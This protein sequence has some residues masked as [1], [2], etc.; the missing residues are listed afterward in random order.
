MAA[1]ARSAVCVVVVGLTA[2][3]TPAVA[4]AAPETTITA[5]PSGRTGDSSPSFA[6]ESSDPEATFECSLD[7]AGFSPC[8]SPTA[9]AGVTESPHT[10]AVRSVDAAGDADPTPAERSFVADASVDATVSAAQQQAQERAHILV[11]VRIQANERLRAAVRGTIGLDKSSFDLKPVRERVDSGRTVVRLRP[12]AA[13]A[14]AIAKAL[15]RGERAKAR[16]RV[17]LADSLG[18]E[19]K[20]PVAVS[21]TG[22]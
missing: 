5:G 1:A 9:Y 19:L 16:L 3:I 8:T 20:V 10:F 17:A 13:D 18:N 7:G 14:R 6:F 2:L 12:A 21:L 22:P 4:A 11:A 15:A